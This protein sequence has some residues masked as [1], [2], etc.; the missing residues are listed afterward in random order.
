[1]IDVRVELGKLKIAHPDLI[2]GKTYLTTAVVASATSSTVENNS[3]FVSTDYVVF[4][5]LGEEKTE[6]VLLTSTTGSTTIG[7]TTGPSFAH[8]I[9]TP[10]REIPYNQVEIYTSSTEDGTYTLAATLALS[11][12]QAFTEYVASSSTWYKVR[13]KNVQGTTYSS[14]S[15][16][17]LGTGHGISTLGYMIEEVADEL[18]DPNHL[19]WSYRRLRRYAKD[20]A[21]TLANEIAKLH[22]TCLVAYTTQTASAATELYDLPAR[23]I[24]FRKM[25]IAYTGSDYVRARPENEIMG[26]PETKYYTTDPRYF[27]R[28]TQYGIRPS[29]DLTT[30]STFKLWYNRY[31]SEMSDDNDEHGLPYGA[32]I[33]IV[34]FMLWKAWLS[35]NETRANGYKADYA[36]SRTDYLEQVG[37]DFQ[38][39]RLPTFKTRLSDLDGLAEDIELDY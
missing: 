16:A 9:D 21:I 23:F 25:D 33:A 18:E 4:G 26:L 7:H 39:Y 22:V 10:V 8:A 28:G 2:G 17:V 1:M 15:P 20:G 6:I 12:D 34:N 30:S 19:I 32:H 3:F 13:Y 35:K 31:P 14:Y 37:E 11:V 5:G 36:Q 24:N 29:A 38:D 27:R